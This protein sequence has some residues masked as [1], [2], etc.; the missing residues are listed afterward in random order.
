MPAIHSE[1]F[2]RL[3]IAQ[4][5]V[6]PMRLLILDAGVAQYRDSIVLA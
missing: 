5:L 3:L 4:A 1:P 6:E 2:D